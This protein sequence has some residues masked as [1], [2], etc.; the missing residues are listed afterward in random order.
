MDHIVCG[1]QGVEITGLFLMMH[2]VIDLGF[3]PSGGIISVM[4]PMPP[5]ER[6]RPRIMRDFV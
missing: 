5:I 4:E 2:Q 3:Q 6:T 1:I